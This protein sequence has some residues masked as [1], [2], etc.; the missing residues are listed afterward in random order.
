MASQY[1]LNLKCVLD[2]TQVKQELQ[3]LRQMQNQILGN[4]RGNSVSGSTSNSSNLGNINGLNSTLS[5]L[6]NSINQLN[7]AITKLNAFNQKSLNTVQPQQNVAVAGRNN[8]PFTPALGGNGNSKITSSICSLTNDINATNQAKFLFD[9]NHRTNLIKQYGSLPSLRQ[10]NPNL[11]QQITGFTPQQYDT[12]NNAMLNGG[13]M[14]SKWYNENLQK[15]KRQGA[16]PFLPSNIKQNTGMSA[17][18]KRMLGGL[19]FGAGL[20]AISTGLEASGNTTGASIASGVG[21]VGSYTLMGSAAGPIGAGI[22]AAVGL[23]QVGAEQIAAAFK[24]ASDAASNMAKRIEQAKVVDQTKADI[25]MASADAKALRGNDVEY[26][27]KQKSKYSKKVNQDKNFQTWFLK[28]YGSLEAFEKETDRIE[29]EGYDGINN[30]NLLAEAERRKKLAEQYKESVANLSKNQSRVDSYSS[31]IESLNN[32]SKGISESYR[33]FYSE[34]SFNNLL[35]GEDKGRVESYKKQL[36]EYLKGQK[37]KFEEYRKDGFKSKN[38][39]KVFENIQLTEGRIEKLNSWLENYDKNEKQKAETEKTKVTGFNKIID[40]E[41]L[42]IAQYNE[43]NDLN[44]L[45]KTGNIS[46]IREAALK[47]RANRNSAFDLYQSTLNEAAL[48]T[49]SKT[50]EELLEKANKYKSD[51]QYSSNTF[52]N[53]NQNLGQLLVAPL[54]DALSKL[55]APNMENVNSLASQGVMINRADDASREQSILDYQREQTD[56]QR[57]IKDL[58]EV[59]DYTGSQP[60]IIQ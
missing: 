1:S 58:L 27:K 41:K 54:Q 24:E 48:A 2:T 37:A 26:F 21:T 14:G 50:K 52:D 43:T 56:L 10:S 32:R 34:K 6:T 53:L 7:N 49:D 16:T 23:I 42:G 28:Q 18:H 5:R 44:R 51:W 13:L 22:G 45:I 3:K 8:I 33:K 9:T 4:N 39:E 19:A 36:E 12:L 59:E 35:G 46:G 47:H 11:L 31:T 60:A 55:Q 57:Q 20:N 25:D 38:S 40:A 17:E 30:D 29:Q 15:Y